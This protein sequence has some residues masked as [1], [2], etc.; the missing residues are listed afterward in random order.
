MCSQLLLSVLRLSQLS[1][2]NTC[3]LDIIAPLFTAKVSIVLAAGLRRSDADGRS[4]E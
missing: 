1:Q 3:L 4:L 2:R